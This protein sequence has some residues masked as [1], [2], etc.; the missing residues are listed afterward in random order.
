MRTPST[1]CDTMEITTSVGCPNACKICPQELFVG[2]YRQTNGLKRLSFENFEKYLDKIPKHVRIDFSGFTEPW[3]NPECTDMILYAH[4]RGFKL[5]VFTTCVGMTRSDLEKIRHI[6][7]VTFVVHLPDDRSNMPFPR[8]SGYKDVLE[9][10]G[11]LNIMNMNF[12]TMGSL[13]PDLHELFCSNVA[14]CVFSGRAG[15]VAGRRQDRKT[16]VIR[17][18]VSPKMHR[19]ILLPNGDIVLC[20]HDYGMEN[21]LGNL[22]TGNYRDLFNGQQYKRITARQDNENDG[23]LLCRY[24]DWSVSRVKGE[25]IFLCE[26]LKDTIRPLKKLTRRMFQRDASL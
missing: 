24:C 2:R 4:E 3:L 9:N 19:N 6:P 1:M 16:G 25:Y 26:Y 7:F 14:G 11:S 18:V 17:C 20:C 22:N 5:T 21:V 13:H 23:D 10:L 15:N 8:V 12:M